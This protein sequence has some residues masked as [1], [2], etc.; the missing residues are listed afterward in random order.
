MNSMFYY[1]GSLECNSRIT[2]LPVVEEQL[3]E[4]RQ[5]QEADVHRK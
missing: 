5:N 2:H 1:T 4:I 3:K